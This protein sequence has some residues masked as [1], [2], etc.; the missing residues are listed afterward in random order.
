MQKS[1]LT[2]ADVAARAGVSVATVSRVVNGRYGVSEQTAAR[3]REVIDEMGYA[4]SLVAQSLRSEK[5]GVIGVLMSRIEPFGTEILKAVSDELQ[6]SGYELVVFCP[7]SE[8][9]EGWERRSLARLGGTL[10][11]GS[12]LV[13]PTVV[14]VSSD[15]PVVAIDPHVGAG[16]LPTVAGENREGAM[17]ATRH[18]IELGHRRIGFLGGRTDLESAAQ[19]EAGYCA[20]LTAAG[21][22]VDPD[23][24]VH[25]D[26]TEAGAEAPARRLLGLRDRPTAVFAANDRSAMRVLQLA[27]EQGLDVPGDLSV[28]GFDDVPEAAATTPPLTTVDQ[29]IR[30]LGREAVRLLFALIDR[31]DDQPDEPIHRLMPVE[32]VVRGST[33]PP[34]SPHPSR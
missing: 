33:A 19:R 31:D 3:V 12:L 9:A 28:V 6:D 29:R 18:L 7:T 16:H 21:L 24:I 34:R 10:V 4:Q 1:R 14:D 2:I 17:A 23:L 5:T 30:G 13:A 27:A 26:F 20:A 32:L 25:G 8:H 15:R 22:D 11:D